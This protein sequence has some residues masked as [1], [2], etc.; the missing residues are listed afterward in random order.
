MNTPNVLPNNLYTIDEAC[1]ALRKSR[2]TLLRYR[3]TGG[4]RWSIRQ[5]DHRIVFTGQNILD[6]FFKLEDYGKNN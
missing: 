2:K 6:C 3:E 4:L 1:Q 5:S